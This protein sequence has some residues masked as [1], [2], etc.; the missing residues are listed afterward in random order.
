LGEVITR[1]IRE[2]GAK[3]P[4]RDMP[5]AHLLEVAPKV[6]RNRCGIRHSNEEYNFIAQKFPRKFGKRCANER[7]V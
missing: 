7:L 3:Y 1:D 4:F 2:V 5:H 6:K